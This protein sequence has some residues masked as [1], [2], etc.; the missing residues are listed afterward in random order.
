MRT[1]QIAIADR[2]YANQI[3]DLLVRDGTHRVYI[4]DAP[5]PSVDGII[6]LDDRLVDDLPTYDLDRCVVL[7]RNTLEHISALFDSGVRHLVFVGDSPG[8]A[9]L[10]ILGVEL[11]PSRG[12]RDAWPVHQSIGSIG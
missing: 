10:A 3:R 1:V 2:R 7:S 9:R 11:R 6:L 4:V 8:T 5:D 12:N